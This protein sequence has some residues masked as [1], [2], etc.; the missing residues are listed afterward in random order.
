MDLT[1]CIECGAGTYQDQE[2]QTTCKYCNAS[3]SSDVGSKSASACVACEEGRFMSSTEVAYV[4]RFAGWCKNP[5]HTF[6]WDHLNPKY[7][8]EEW[9]NEPS[10]DKDVSDISE[11][12]PLFQ[13]VDIQNID[14]IAK[15]K[16]MIYADACANACRSFPGFIVY[17]APDNPTM[18]AV[19]VQCLYIEL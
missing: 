14:N 5:F 15:T 9:R 18:V 12:C 6:C 1:S 16:D 2:G 4:R 19:I 11:T 8:D 13:Q 3:E 10:A 7:S 17:H